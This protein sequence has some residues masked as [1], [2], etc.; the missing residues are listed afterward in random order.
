M[1]G[2]RDKVINVFKKIA[3]VNK[4]SLP[5]LHPYTQTQVIF[6]TILVIT[7]ARISM[8]LH[9]FSKMLYTMLFKIQIC[10]KYTLF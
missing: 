9:N 1:Q 5:D 3:S 6:K 10:V 8:Q 2:K 7:R 4:K